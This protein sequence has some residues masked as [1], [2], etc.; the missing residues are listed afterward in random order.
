[1]NLRLFDVLIILNL[2]WLFLP[3]CRNDSHFESKHESGEAQKPTREGE[4]VVFAAISLTDALTEISK[5]FQSETGIRVFC[6]F[7]GSST[8]QQQIENG[9]YT[10]IFICASPKQMD[11][12]RSVGHVYENTRLNLLTNSLVLICP[13]KRYTFFV[14]SWDAYC[15]AN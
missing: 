13:F 14:R 9:A 6:N 4:L 10:D 3:G 15:T 8:L 1:M 5:R 11:S 12:L 7:A 2:F